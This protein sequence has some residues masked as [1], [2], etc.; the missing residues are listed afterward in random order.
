M[1]G[2]DDPTAIQSRIPSRKRSE[3]V[4]K[5]GR[6]VER[7]SSE[8]Y[9]RPRW[10]PSGRFRCLRANRTETFPKRSHLA[11]RNPHKAENPCTMH[12][13]S[14]SLVD[15]TQASTRTITTTS[16]CSLLKM[17]SAASTGPLYSKTTEK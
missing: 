4:R 13:C 6:N 5:Q 9:G 14:T 3:N 16:L 8:S 17:Q 1:L 7:T 15:L 10:V 12:G 2:G 11:W